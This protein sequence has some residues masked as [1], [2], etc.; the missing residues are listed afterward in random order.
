MARAYGSQ[1]E[2][3]LAYESTYGQSPGGNF[4]RMPFNRCDLGAEQGLLDNDIIGLGRDPADP[5]NDLVRSGGQIAVPLDARNIGFWLKLVFGD[6]VTVGTGP[7]THTWTSGGS[8]LPSASIEVGLPQVPAFFVNLGVKADSIRIEV[9]RTGGAQAVLQL[10]GQD[11]QKFATSQGG[12]PAAELPILR[13]NQAQ[14]NV[15]RDGADLANV[16][17]ASMEYRNNLEAVETIR[18]DQLVEGHDETIAALSGSLTTR[19]ASTTLLDDASTGTAIGL[20]VI[21][22]I[23][24]SNR[25]SLRG[26]RV[27]LPRPK[28]PIDGPGG[29]EAT[30]DFQGGLLARGLHDLGC[31]LA[32]GGNEEAFGFVEVGLMRDAHDDL[33]EDVGGSFR[34]AHLGVAGAL[35]GQHPLESVVVDD[36][37]KE[38]RIRDQDGAAR[39]LLAADRATYLVQQDVGQG[40]VDDVAD[41]AGDDHAIADLEGT[42]HDDHQ[43]GGDAG[44]RRLQR[45]AEHHAEEG[46]G[47]PEGRQ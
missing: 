21:Y 24:A 9:S 45:P 6:P 43:P 4:R 14:G 1:V 47:D 26:Q 3:L 38:G 5:F 16:V 37:L 7:Y 2:L 30:F 17:S 22:T 25:L 28:R 34:G 40:D 35:G 46:G 20:D 18:P 27:R 36:L 19:F 29:V 41:D 8:S 15:Q 39:L 11:E 12:T 13:F 33:V 10:A 32:G 23:D 44:D 31:H 42:L